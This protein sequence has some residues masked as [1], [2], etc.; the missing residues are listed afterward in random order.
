MCRCHLNSTHS[1]S[2]L[3]A[4]CWATQIRNCR[5]KNYFCW[6][7]AC[8]KKSFNIFLVEKHVKCRCLSMYFMGKSCF[9]LNYVLHCIIICSVFRVYQ[10]S[11]LALCVPL[12]RCILHWG[13][14]NLMISNVFFQSYKVIKCSLCRNPLTILYSCQ[15]NQITFQYGI[16][17]LGIKQIWWPIKPEAY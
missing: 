6:I 9:I 8:Y 3:C 2:I 14:H 4:Q 10:S 12:S 13:P 7:E 5:G 1:K 15:I 11:Y 17:T 16:K